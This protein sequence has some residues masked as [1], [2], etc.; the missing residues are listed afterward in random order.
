MLIADIIAGLLDIR[1]LTA[2]ADTLEK[3]IADA[4]Q[5]LANL[6]RRMAGAVRGVA[7][8]RFDPFQGSGGQQSFST[9]LVTEE[10]SGVVVSG[11]HSRDSVRVYAKP[12]IKFSSER[13]LSEDEK[14]AIEGAKKKL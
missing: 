12:V 14:R 10:G 7:V 11:I 5:K 9:A 3:R 4:E 8:E 1:K 2:R 13:E 6:N